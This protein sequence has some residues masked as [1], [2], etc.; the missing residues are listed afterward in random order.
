MKCIFGDC[1]VVMDPP[2]VTVVIH[3][4]KHGSAVGYYCSYDHA[5]QDSSATLEYM[6]EN[7][8]LDGAPGEFKRDQ[9]FVQNPDA[10][11]PGTVIDVGVEVSAAQPP[12]NF[13]TYT[14]NKQTAQALRQSLAGRIS[15]DWAL[16]DEV[17]STSETE[18]LTELASGFKLPYTKYEIKLDGT[19]FWVMVGYNDEYIWVNVPDANYN[20]KIR[21]DQFNNSTPN[22]IVQHIEVLAANA[23]KPATT[24][25]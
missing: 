5:L 4:L 20:L 2:I 25:A 10:F 7:D 23:K 9:L 1:K 24:L 17:W 21:A 15:G 3:D 11:E 19:D 22:A 14:K 18:E 6:K 16:R 13:K 12:Y 8:K